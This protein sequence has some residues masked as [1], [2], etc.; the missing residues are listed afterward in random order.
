M[1]HKRFEVEQIVAELIRRGRISE[2]TFHRWMKQFTGLEAGPVRSLAENSMRPVALDRNNWI[3]HRKLASG[4]ED[5]EYSFHSG[6]LS[7]AEAFR[8]SDS[9]NTLPL[10][11]LASSRHGEIPFLAPSRTGIEEFGE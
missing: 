9:Q 11:G 7:A 10:R 5:R 1:K 2:Q 4:T 8:P 3:S 6:K